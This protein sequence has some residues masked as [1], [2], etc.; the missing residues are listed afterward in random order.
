[1]VDDNV[2]TENVSTD[3]Y[4]N[5]YSKKLALIEVCALCDTA[6]HMSDY[7]DKMNLIYMTNLLIICETYKHQPHLSLNKQ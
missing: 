6:Y 1:M 5:C 4:L 3:I 2:S 7:N